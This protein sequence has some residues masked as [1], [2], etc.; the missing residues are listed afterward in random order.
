[1]NFSKVNIHGFIIM[2]VFTSVS[3]EYLQKGKRIGS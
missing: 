2:D 3:T 1:M